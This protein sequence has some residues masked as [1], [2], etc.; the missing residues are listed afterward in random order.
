MAPVESSFQRPLAG[1]CRTASARQELEEPS[2]L[3]DICSRE[4]VPTLA[5]ASSMASGMPSSLV[6]ISPMARA[7]WAVNAKEGSW[8]RARARNSRADSELSSSS[9][10][11]ERSGS[12]ALRGGT[13][14]LSSPSTQRF[15]ARCQYVQ[16]RA[17]VEQDIHLPRSSLKEVLA[18]VQDEEQLFVCQDLR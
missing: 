2:S 18:V 11:G 8:P 4:R 15:A 3:S 5:A 9:T 7:F 1:R 13:G 6:Q 12:G 17:R 16:A 14:H 10:V